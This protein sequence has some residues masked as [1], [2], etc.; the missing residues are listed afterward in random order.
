MFIG[1]SIIILLL[2]YLSP[3]AGYSQAQND[4]D[5][6]S[7][8]LSVPRIGSW[9]MPAIIKEQSAYLPVKELFDILQIKN[10]PSAGLDSIK[11][12]FINPKAN[13]LF[14]KIN[15]RIVCEDKIFNLKPTD[16]I[17]FENNL[18]LKSDY[19]GQI[20]GLECIFNFRS[21]SITINTK[22]E[23]PAIREMQLEQMR[24]NITK[25]KGDKKADT[26]I[27]RKFSM[28]HLGMADWSII[29]FKQSEG[30]NYTRI[31]ANL[32]AVIAGGEAT[33]YLNYT[34]G[35]PFDL[36]QQYYRWRYVDNDN[37]AFRQV[38]AGNIFVQPT[39]SVYGAITGIQITN[40]PTT[41]RRSFGT[42]R[43]S[44]T[45]EP[46]WMVELYVNNVLINYTKA[47]ASGFYTFEVPLVYGNTVV[48]LRFYGTWGEERSSEQNIS[49]PFNFL[50]V[51]QFEYSLSAGII[52][53]DQK[54]RFSRVNFN[55]GLGSHI[56]VGGGMEY[57]S[58]VSAGKSMPFLNTSL[59][60]GSNLL[61]SAEHTYGVRSKAIISYRLP[62]S[63][64]F[65]VNYTKYVPGQTAIR[66]GKAVGNNYIEDRKAVLFM[67]FRTKKFSGFSRFSISQLTV[68]K[69]KY[70]TAELL[71]SGM[72]SGIN[73]N[74]T[75]SAV[76]SDPS[77]PLVYSNLAM[78]FRLPK[79]IRVTPQAQYEYKGKKFSMMKCEL[80]KNLWNRGFMILGYENNIAYK[81]NNFSLGIRYNFSFAQTSF[82]I[83]QNNGAASYIQ[84]ARGSL[85]YNDRSNNLKFTSQSNV[86][87][88][89]LVVM[90]FLD[91]NCNGKRDPGE[92]KASGLKLRING[93]RLEHNKR[94]TTIIITGLDAY[95]NYYVELDKNS[96]DNIGWQ[97]RKSTMN[98]VIEPNHFKLIE[99]PVA[100]VGEVSGTVYTQNNKG[101]N[102]LGRV[103]VNFYN[104]DST[105]V[106]RTV[107]E[108]DGY[109]SFV[110]LV[111]GTY[112]VEIDGAQLLRLNMSSFPIKLPVT[113][114]LNRDGDIIDGLK[115]IIKANASSKN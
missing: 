26:I 14:D 63:L 76:Y 66:S 12:F 31:T 85:I 79:G 60:V 105:L 50:P 51:N 97:L 102:G 95:T 91:F 68:P 71:L 58:S 107:T 16:L 38:T 37:S 13:Y 18:Y 41:Y 54:S 74:L 9:E 27:K 34:S 4:Y 46:G 59:R 5:E 64:Q 25:L 83:S 8:T 39:A 33:M 40:T 87:R 2:M 42:Y 49:I 11:G 112:A 47:D 84:S 10:S 103:I 36:K 101:I 94:D 35:Q 21:L 89:G 82:S 56:T 29:N 22:L 7:V 70:T 77:H 108:S 96:F 81:T 6:I 67:P 28:F 57:L 88:G 110:G 100:V 99:V 72:V 44:N 32:G 52:D 53:D 111:P 65:E 48:K 73:T 78:T 20:F 93:G 114:K 104:A 45:T 62:S 113:I 90:P 106:G 15:D 75:T 24:R 30:F 23:L 92:P 1:R 80:E 55:Y 17:R 19:F 98:V 109:F 43:I 86:G 115:F 69:L 3:N 61:I